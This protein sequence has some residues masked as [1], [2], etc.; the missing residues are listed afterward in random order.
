MNPAP[1][2][3]PLSAAE[4]TAESTLF[5]G[6]SAAL[7]PWPDDDPRDDLSPLPPFAPVPEP[8][9]CAAPPPPLPSDR[10]SKACPAAPLARSFR[11][12]PR[13]RWRPDPLPEPGL[14]SPVAPGM[15]SQYWSSADLPGSDSH[16]VAPMAGCAIARQ[17]N[18]TVKATA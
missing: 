5:E 13:E 3:E 1:L 6:S 7:S 17:N 4:R 11:S 16:R 8:P 18:A 15:V 2:L 9:D 10:P 14:L 12:V